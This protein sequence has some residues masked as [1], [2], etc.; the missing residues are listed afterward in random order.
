LLPIIPL[1]SRTV[2]DAFVFER[3]RAACW[4]E[5]APPTQ[6]RAQRAAAITCSWREWCALNN[7][8]GNGRHDRIHRD[9]GHA[10]PE[11]ARAA[12]DLGR[13]IAIIGCST[14]KMRIKSTSAILRPPRIALA[15]G[16][17]RTSEP[18]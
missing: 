5:R 15:S 4:N 3:S 12:S 6:G 17:A 9:I 1:A 18:R 8:V 11:L 13:A 14:L 7:G 10:A 16:E 2:I